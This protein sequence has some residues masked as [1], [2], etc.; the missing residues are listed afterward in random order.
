MQCVMRRKQRLTI[1]VNHCIETGG[2][3]NFHQQ[4]T[5]DRFRCMGSQCILA[6]TQFG[7]WIQNS[8]NLWA[9]I[10][11]KP[12]V[13][14][15]FCC[16]EFVSQVLSAKSCFTQINADRFG[17]LFCCVT[18]SWCLS[19]CHSCAF[20]KVCGFLLSYDFCI[21]PWS[22]LCWLISNLLNSI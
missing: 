20:I 19:C 11:G 6:S 8:W 10:Y 3:V 4:K 13:P 1:K 15:Y 5:P 2:L 17:G 9:S 16:W 18:L 7:L 21:M 22:D 12:V 14:G